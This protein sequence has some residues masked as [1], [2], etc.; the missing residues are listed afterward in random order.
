MSA[1]CF[2]GSDWFTWYYLGPA[3]HCYQLP[4]P[5]LVEA[6]E[7]GRGAIWLGRV[8]T[9]IDHSGLDGLQNAEQGEAG[10]QSLRDA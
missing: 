1:V 3:H 8:M 10:A 6:G 9:S 4:F 5:Q 2:L 7:Q